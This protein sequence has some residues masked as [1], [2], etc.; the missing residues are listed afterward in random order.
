MS[1]SRSSSRGAQRC[2]GFLPKRRSRSFSV[3]RK[4]AAAVSGGPPA[5]S[6]TA[7]TALRY[8][9]WPGRP[10]GRVAYSRE[11]P[12]TRSP[13]VAAS[14]AT[15]AARVPSRSPR[16][17]PRPMYARTLR[18]VSH[19]LPAVDH[20]EVRSGTGGRGAVPGPSIRAVHARADDTIERIGSA[21]ER[22]MQGLYYVLGFAFA[23][24]SFV[25]LT[26]AASWLLSHHWSGD[27][28]KG[29][30]YESGIDTY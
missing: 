25:L 11:T 19:C 7:A 16:F 9:G 23:G 13:G 3:R 24:V 6:S 22:S 10:T 17:A 5:R 18:K 1:R 12:T 28:H 20:L 8:S 30:P 26:I 15:A 2:R 27:H 4:S 29:L 21:L 14:A